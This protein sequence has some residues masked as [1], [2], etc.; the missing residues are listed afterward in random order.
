VRLDGVESRFELDFTGP[1][2]L[3]A[4]MSNSL[5]VPFACKGGMCCTCRA[6]LEKGEVDM[7]LNYALTPEEVAEGY[8]LTCQSHPRTAEVQVNYDAR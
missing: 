2:I 4:A 1:S 5:D 3:D 8:I 7:D 6:K